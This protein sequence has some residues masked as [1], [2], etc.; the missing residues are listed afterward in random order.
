M[1]SSA[2]FLVR[3]VVTGLTVALVAM[4]AGFIAGCASS[5]PPD[6]VGLTATGSL[7]PC[8]SKPNCVSSLAD[9]PDFRVEPIPVETGTVDPLAPLVDLLEADPRA[10]VV[11]VRDRYVR[12]EFTSRW[13]GFVDD[14]EFLLDRENAR[15]DVR[16][17]S[18]VGYSDLGV[19]R[20]RVDTLRAA[21]IEATRG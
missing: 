17:A 7:R 1:T 15:I 11:E 2:R 18:R 14:V 13:F 16:S 4:I 10:E 21:Y 8:G 5:R 9:D 19:N 20:S 6:D 12:A 3:V